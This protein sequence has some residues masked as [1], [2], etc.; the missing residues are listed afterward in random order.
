M[1][2]PNPSLGRGSATAHGSRLRDG[3][4]RHR[5]ATVAGTAILVVAAL[6]T[7]VGWRAMAVTT[8]VAPPRADEPQLERLETALPSEVRMGSGPPQRLSQASVTRALAIFQGGEQG[9]QLFVLGDD[10]RV[11]LLDRVDLGHPTD[12]EGN[13]QVAVD[14]TS[15]SPDGSRAAFAQHDKVVVVDLTTG[16]ANHFP[17]PGYN[18]DVVWRDGD[19]LI[20]EQRRSFL[21][22]L[23]TG[24]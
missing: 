3:R 14:T 13:T 23:G 1:I 5:T 21:L 8:D 17:L 20:V 16:K 18:R 4:R 2:S 9:D 15:L 12:P 22:D 6:V 7:M 24:K 11:R 19:T 10:W